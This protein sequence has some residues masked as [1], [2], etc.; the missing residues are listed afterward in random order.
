MNKL[1]GSGSY[2]KVIYFMTT[3]L[4]GSAVEDRSGGSRQNYLE[5]LK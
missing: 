5:D 2:G 3:G 1:L 4:L